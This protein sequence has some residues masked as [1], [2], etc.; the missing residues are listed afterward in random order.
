MGPDYGE[1]WRASDSAGSALVLLVAGVWWIAVSLVTGGGASFGLGGYYKSQLDPYLPVSMEIKNEHRKLSL[2]LAVA[3]DRS[4]SMAAPV[5]DGRTKMD[6]ANLGTC[7][8]I[9]SLGP[10]DQVGVIAV[11]SAPHL[12]QELTAADN[13]EGICNR[14]RGIQSR[15]GFA[16]ASSHSFK[17]FWTPDAAL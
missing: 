5:G 3:L 17:A 14:V 4:G 1:R 6:L 9:E 8:A 2:A 7:A 12:V 15:G 13:T 11:D 10:F 16:P